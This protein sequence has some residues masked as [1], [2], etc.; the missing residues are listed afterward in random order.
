MFYGIIA[1]ANFSSEPEGKEWISMIGL[2]VLFLLIDI[3]KWI[4]HYKMSYR[5]K[6]GWS[7]FYILYMIFLLGITILLPIKYI[8]LVVVF[9]GLTVF[10]IYSDNKNKNGINEPVAVKPKSKVKL[11]TI[12]II[13]LIFLAVPTIHQLYTMLMSGFYLIVNP[14]LFGYPLFALRFIFNILVV[15][16]SF[17]A[18]K[19]MLDNPLTPWI[20]TFLVIFSVRA[21]EMITIALINEKTYRVTEMTIY[22]YPRVGLFPLFLL[23]CYIVGYLIFLMR[24]D[25][26]EINQMK[27][28]EIEK[29]SKETEF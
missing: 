14:S 20:N 1:L 13:A 28:Q 9:Y 12:L 4:A 7:V 29:I 2:I 18:L 26:P 24:R 10:I 8:Y 6:N 23:V 19:K 25:H 17:Y 16:Y 21:V 5:Y 27:S 3:S 11:D 22:Q 15:G